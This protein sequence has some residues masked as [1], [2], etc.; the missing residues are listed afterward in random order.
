MT[1]AILVLIAEG[2]VFWLVFFRL[3]LLRLTP[4]WAVIFLFIMAPVF[5]VFLIGLRFLTAVSATATIIQQTIRLIPSLTE[6]TPVTAVLVEENTMVKKGQPLFRFDHRP[7][8]YQVKQFKAQ[9]AA[10]KQ[11][12]RVLQADVEIAMQK[13]A[14]AEVDL[15]YEQYQ[16]RIFARLVEEQAV[17]GE[18]AV[19]V[20]AKVN[21]AEATRAAAKAELERARLQYESEIDGVNT[22]VAS[23]EAQLRQALSY[24][25]NT[26]LA[27]PEDGRIVNLQVRPGM[28]SGTRRV[29]GIAALITE[30][31]RYLLATFYQ[32]NLKYVRPDQP[33]EVA[34]DLYPGE[35]FAGKVH[36]LCRAKGV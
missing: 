17:R 5:V 6:P 19:Q 10:A 14:K 35:G 25:D 27:A 1:A 33:V 9:L 36:S 4:T 24:L 32:E 31:D 30:S 26:T 20:D 16:K 12:V 11:N 15:N 29:G 21:G 13:L 8:E 34:L 28:V 18:Q 23:L 3:K 22:A 7:Y 2:T